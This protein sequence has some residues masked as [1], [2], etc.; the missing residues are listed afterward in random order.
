MFSGTSQAAPLIQQCWE[1]DVTQILN[2][3]FYSD[4]KCAML[5]L[6]GQPWILQQAMGTQSKS[7]C[8]T[9]MSPPRTTLLV[10][11]MIY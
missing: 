1:M 3:D 7:A 11:W 4:T 2:V 5:P 9:N 6:A 10:L 8:K